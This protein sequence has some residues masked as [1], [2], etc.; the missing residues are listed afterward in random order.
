[1]SKSFSLHKK[2]FLKKI[3]T[4]SNLVKSITLLQ[5]LIILNLLGLKLFAQVELLTYTLKMFKKFNEVY[6]VQK[7]TMKSINFSRQTKKT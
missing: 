2:G 1:M 5:V 3:Q 4:A 6:A 7:K